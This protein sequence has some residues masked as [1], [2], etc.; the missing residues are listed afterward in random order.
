MNYLA[1]VS[2]GT[3]AQGLHNA[4]SMLVGS[5]REDIISLGL[6]NDMSA[7]QFAE[8]FAEKLEIIKPDD[9]LILLGDLI[10]GSPLTNAINQVC[11]KNLAKQT[12]VF[13]GMN[14]A[15]ALCAAMQKDMAD[16]EELREAI[17]SEA[18]CIIKEYPL[19]T[20]DAEDEDDEI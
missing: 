18:Q 5:D 20:E 10:G 4:I 19:F 3:F 1:L 7:D 6:E 13:G 11:E 9:Q 8:L 2:H 16:E 12:M 15:M 17:L 14:L